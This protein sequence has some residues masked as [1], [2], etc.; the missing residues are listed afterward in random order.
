MYQIQHLRTNDDSPHD[1]Q[2]NHRENTGTS[3]INQQWGK[4]ANY[5]Y[6]KQ[7]D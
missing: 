2:H 5:T 6:E 3:E 4:A 1:F 7:V